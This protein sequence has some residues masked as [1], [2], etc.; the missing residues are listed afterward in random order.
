MVILI[1]R[2]FKLD[3][4]IG[5]FS[6]KT[7]NFTCGD[8][9]CNTLH[10]YI[11]LEEKPFVDYLLL[12]GTTLADLIPSEVRLKITTGDTDPGPL[13]NHI[14]KI[15]GKPVAQFI[16]TD[17]Y[18]PPIRTFDVPT[19]VYITPGDTKP[20]CIGKCEIVFIGAVSEALGLE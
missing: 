9:K 13:Q 12:R 7:E 17:G 5:F 10:E 6:D 20:E 14:F 3:G 19:V 15:Y 1:A 16:I 2:K 18:T 11:A 8:V 4:V